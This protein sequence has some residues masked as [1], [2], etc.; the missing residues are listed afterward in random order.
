MKPT[1]D[2][3]PEYLPYITVRAPNPCRITEET[4]Q[5]GDLM[6]DLGK[7]EVGNCQHVDTDEKTV[8]YNWVEWDGVYTSSCDLQKA[9]KLAAVPPS[10]D[11]NQIKESLNQ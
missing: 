1:F 5:R 8:D 11:V 9:R 6:I 7:W 3:P 2:I 10:V 4:P